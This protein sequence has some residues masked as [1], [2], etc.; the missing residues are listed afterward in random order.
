MVRSLLKK[1]T[2]MENS[3][4]P[5]EGDDVQPDTKNADGFP[6]DE[7]FSCKLCI[8]IGVGKTVQEK[9]LCAKKSIRIISP[10]LGI[11]MVEHLCNAYLRGIND[12]HLITS[13][14]G[15]FFDYIKIDVLKK[16][17]QQI[18]EPEP[19]YK[20]ILDTKFFKKEKGFPFIHGKLYIID[21]EIAFAGSFNFTET[22][23]KDNI[24]TRLIIEDSAVI[25]K[26]SKYFDDLSNVDKK[27][28]WEVSELGKI[29]YEQHHSVFDAIS[30]ILEKSDKK[31]P[32]DAEGVLKQFSRQL[33]NEYPD[34]KDFF[35]QKDRWKKEDDIFQRYVILNQKM[36]DWALEN[37]K[38]EV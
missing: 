3:Q 12:I 7:K 6:I 10:F 4:P 18:P 23:M 8:G 26:L 24:E 16:L 15:S 28:K 19:K 13:V 30:I 17:I 22:G 5:K 29:V 36:Y 2:L 1:A 14:S 21:D 11:G 32:P 37:I 33:M 27:Y 20:E 38:L 9:I 25:E 34:R 31:M 35:A